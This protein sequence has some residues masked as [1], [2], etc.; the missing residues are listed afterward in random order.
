MTP[1]PNFSSPAVAI[2]EVDALLENAQRLQTPCG[3]GVM[4]WHVWKPESFSVRDAGLPP[5]VLFHGGSGSWTHWLANIEALVRSGRNVYAPDLPGFGDSAAPLEGTDA[6]AL[7]MPVEQGL[8]VLLGGRRCDLV[9]F[10]FGSMV[11]GFI[12][13]QFP[14]RAAQLVLVGSPGLGMAPQPPLQLRLRSWR[15]LADVTARD[16]VQRHN[17]GVLMLY[18]PEAIKETALRVHVANVERDRMKGRS[19]A[20]TDVLLRTLASV[21]CPVSAIYGMEDV[22]YRGRMAELSAALQSTP[23]FRGLKLLENAGH[24]VQYERPE[25]F[26]SALLAALSAGLQPQRVRPAG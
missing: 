14:A 21:H 9:A 26:N 13:A 25:V 3:E 16:A 1:L 20:R 6:D 4:V 10:S 2:P 5:L 17:L 18:R 11:A 23:D 22:L 8:R 7:P 19:L 15:H 12:A 24:W